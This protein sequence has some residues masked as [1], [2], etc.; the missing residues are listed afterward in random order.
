MSQELENKLISIIQNT[1][2]SLNQRL[3]KLIA[4]AEKGKD[5]PELEAPI[6]LLSA[7]D[8]EEDKRR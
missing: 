5:L 7:I 6:S 4:E 3:N 8:I 1:D 2:F